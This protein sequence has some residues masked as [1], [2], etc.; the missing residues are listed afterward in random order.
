MPLNENSPRP[1]RGSERRLS[2]WN[3]DLPPRR[4]APSAFPACED[5]HA[6]EVCLS[7]IRRIL[8]TQRGP[9]GAEQAGFS[10]S[11]QAIMLVAALGALCEPLDASAQELGDQEEVLSISLNLD[12]FELRRG[13]GDESL[14]SDMTATATKG[15]DSLAFKFSS[16]IPFSSVFGGV[17]LQARYM[18]QVSPGISLIAGLR[19]DQGAGTS[20][21][22]PYVGIAIS[23]HPVLGTEM[24]FFRS[25]DGKILGRAEAVGLVPIAGPFSIEG[26]VE[27]NWASTTG[28]FG[29]GGLG[30]LEMS[31]RALLQADDRTQFYAGVLHA[32][33]LGKAE[34]LA[35]QDGDST[36]ITSLVFGTRWQM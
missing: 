27:A 35:R 8:R 11:R 31:S 23:P 4:V 29:P 2:G 9:A 14:F 20:D 1:A 32:Q 19:T 28:R 3:I 18:R 30:N 24:L 16:D 25:E 26:K 5:F 21:F 33:L 7:A 6:E 36:A 22:Y 10:R 15:A 17:E 12:Y 13:E 34:R